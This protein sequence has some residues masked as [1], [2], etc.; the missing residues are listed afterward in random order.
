MTDKVMITIESVVHITDL[1]KRTQ[2]KD[3][4]RTR[5]KTAELL[6]RILFILATHGE[7]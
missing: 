6:C 2:K 5:L 4:G 3:V 7:S 1:M